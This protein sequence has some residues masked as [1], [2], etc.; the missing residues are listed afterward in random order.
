MW[1]LLDRRNAA[2]AG[3][4]LALLVLAL[5]ALTAAGGALPA[6]PA[7][8]APMDPQAVRE[9]IAQRYEVIPIRGGVLLQPRKE[10]L[11]VRSIEVAGASIAINGERM[12]L[13]TVRE[14]LGPQEAAPVLRLLDMSPGDRRALFGLARE[15]AL[16][17]PPE[18]APDTPDVPDTDTDTNTDTDTSGVD[19]DLGSVDTDT[20]VVPAPP[21]PPGLPGSTSGDESDEAEDEA[22]KARIGQQIRFGTGVTVDKGEIAESVA[23]IGGSVRVD[24][25][26]EDNVAAIFGSVRI[27]G[28]VGGN[29]SAVGGK[30]YLGPKAEIQGNLSAVG[31]TIQRQPG[32]KVYGSTSEVPGVLGG[33]GGDW[34]WDGDVHVSPWSPFGAS[35]RL[36]STLTGLLILALL[37][38]LTILLA[39][40]P[41]ELADAHLRAEPWKCALV[42]VLAALFSLPLLGV[43][44]ALLILTVVGCLLFLL[45]PFLAV[46]FVLVLILGYAAAAHRLGRWTEIRFGW[47]PGGVFRA[48][49]IGVLLIEIW[50]VLGRVLA[51]G[52]GPLDWIAGTILLFG[53]TVRAAAW[54]VGFGSVLLAWFANRPPRWR[55]TPA[56][57][58]G[59]TPVSYAP[60]VP[61]GPGGPGV[62]VPPLP[63][64]P[65]QAS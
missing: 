43:V 22:S 31:G 15:G 51:L 58:V 54:T 25:E 8:P 34:D 4:A 1:T 53:F 18:A 2:S 32:A 21:V 23:A 62:G 47:A 55:P 14:W 29:V 19:T 39:R 64:E 16:P 6:Q 33:V 60:A 27:N 45:Y 52:S 26:V 65:D 44:T 37:V 7:P 13:A 57:P 30:V 36:F 50:T 49:M 10:R 63:V 42:G 61:V 11:A 38:G 35:V 41:L 48:A 28:R 9:L 56:G 20:S 5:A 3:R 17:V 46:F 24:G 40:R 12:P 59:G